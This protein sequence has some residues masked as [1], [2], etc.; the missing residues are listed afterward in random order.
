MGPNFQLAKICAGDYPG[1]DCENMRSAKI[2]LSPYVQST[3][4][5]VK[6]RSVSRAQSSPSIVQKTADGGAT[7]LGQLGDA[8]SHAGCILCHGPRGEHRQRERQSAD[9]AVPQPLRQRVRGLVAPDV[10]Q[11]PERELH[12]FNM[13]AR[14]CTCAACAACAWA[15][16]YA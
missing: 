4:H 3:T 13:T 14:T 7:G 2:I 6:A 12:R 9:L 5:I 1:A 16:L 11:D 15:C 10:V 8:P